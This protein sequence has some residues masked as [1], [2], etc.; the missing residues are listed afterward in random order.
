MPVV[1]EQRRGVDVQYRPASARVQ[2]L[3][4]LVADFAGPRGT[5]Q[6]Q[7]VGRD[8]LAVLEDGKWRVLSGFLERERLDGSDAEQFRERGI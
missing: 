4:F 3:D 2:D 5:P 7:I 1:V 8:R 6:R